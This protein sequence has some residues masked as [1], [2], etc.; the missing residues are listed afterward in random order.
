M[1]WAEGFDGERGAPETGHLNQLQRNRGEEQQRL[2]SFVDELAKRFDFEKREKRVIDELE[3]LQKTYREK[4]G[5][6]RTY[7]KLHE[8]RME[9]LR[10]LSP[11]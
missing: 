10:A 8:L 2:V 3:S 1:S 9:D 5:E 7:A 11:Q 6:L 4:V